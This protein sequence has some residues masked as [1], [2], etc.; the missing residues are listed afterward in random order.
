MIP[1][2]HSNR[3]DIP[4]SNYSFQFCSFLSQVFRSLKL[5]NSDRILRI[6]LRYCHKYFMQQIISMYNDDCNKI[7]EENNIVN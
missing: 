5:L 1:L 7:N 3:I 2:V 4:N 6:C